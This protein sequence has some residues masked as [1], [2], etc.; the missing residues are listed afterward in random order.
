[1]ELRA[2]R[3]YP[4]GRHRRHR[5]L[6]HRW[7]V[8]HRL[9]HPPHRSPHRHRCRTRSPTPFRDRRQRCGQR[10]RVS[11]DRLITR[12]RGSVVRSW[13]KL[14]AV[15]PNSKSSYWRNPSTLESATV[16]E[17]IPSTPDRWSSSLKRLSRLYQGPKTSTLNLSCQRQSDIPVQSAE[18]FQHRASHAMRRTG[19]HMRDRS[20]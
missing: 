14:D 6:R 2:L 1:M 19:D 7:T 16:C 13:R 4:H 8:R 18:T 20:G 15:P 12:T 10:L 9:R 17:R 3:W 5:H 11:D